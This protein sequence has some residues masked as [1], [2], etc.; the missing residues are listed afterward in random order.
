MSDARSRLAERIVA[1][2]RPDLGPHM[3]THALG[4]VCKKATTT[5][6]TLGPQHMDVVE[7]VLGK[8]LR[9]LMGQARSRRVVAW[10]AEK[11]LD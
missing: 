3:A 4:L 9:T 8:I 7:T 5:P 10:I 2:L 6:D 11:E 1:A